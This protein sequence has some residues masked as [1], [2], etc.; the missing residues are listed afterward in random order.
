MTDGPTPRWKKYYEANKEQARKR[1]LEWYHKN[2][3][4][5]RKTGR[6]RAAKRRKD[7][8]EDYRQKRK[9]YTDNNRQKLNEART[10][11]GLAHRFHGIL[12]SSRSMAKKYGYIPCLLAPKELEATFAGHCSICGRLESDTHKLRMDHCHITGKFRGWLCH[13]CNV[14]LGNFLDS[15]II[16]DKAK[17]YLQANA[18]T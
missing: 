3:D 2:G 6:E 12:H 18:T 14:G 11:W 1:Y 10:R 17:E 15:P 8:P 16:L 5:L 7:N 4:R 13:N 9:E